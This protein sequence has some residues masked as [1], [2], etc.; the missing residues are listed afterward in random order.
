MPPTERSHHDRE[1]CPRGGAFLGPAK[2]AVRTAEPRQIRDVSA[3][4][5]N[6]GT[7]LVLHNGISPEVTTKQLR[8]WR[9]IR[10]V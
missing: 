3:G 5:V 10:V 8:R 7:V 4:T 9:K 1:T 2:L 6:K